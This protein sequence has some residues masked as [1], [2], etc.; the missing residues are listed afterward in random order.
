MQSVLI[1]IKVVSLSPANGEVH[2]M[3]TYALNLSVILD[4]PL[5]FLRTSVSSTNKTDCHDVI[6]ILLEVELNTI[7]L[8]RGKMYIHL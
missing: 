2:Y 6:E 1:T 7:T 8:I 4:K 3:Q 5:D